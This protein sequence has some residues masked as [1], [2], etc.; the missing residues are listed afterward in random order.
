MILLKIASTYNTIAIAKER[1]PKEIYALAC[2]LVPTLTML[3]GVIISI[4]TTPIYRDQY[5]FPSLSL[6]ALFFG[7]ALSRSNRYLKTAFCIFLLLTGLAQYKESLYQEYGS[8]LL[9]QDG[10]VVR[11]KRFL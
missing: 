4:Y 7:I 2:M 6:L 10:A 8:T 5:I 9:P 3:A 11:G 1:N